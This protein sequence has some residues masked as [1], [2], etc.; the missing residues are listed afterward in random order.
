MR[1]LEHHVVTLFEKLDALQ[2]SP[3]TKRRPMQ[4]EVRTLE[5]WR[6]VIAECLA[7][8]FLVFF[9]CGASVPWSGISSGK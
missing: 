7:T 4:Q 8:F 2:L 1:S 9:I 3:V 6:A 5:L